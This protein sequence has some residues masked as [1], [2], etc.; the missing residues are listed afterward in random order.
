MT[1]GELRMEWGGFIRGFVDDIFLLH[2]R[3]YWMK[4]AV[5]VFKPEIICKLSLFRY[6]C[7][8]VSL[9]LC[10]CVVLRLYGSAVIWLY[11]LK[12]FHSHTPHNRK[13]SQPH[14]RKTS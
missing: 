2:L 1:Q 4:A 5:N 12:V 3:F 8:K 13:T 10:G 14:N 6:I 9:R 11:G 7:K